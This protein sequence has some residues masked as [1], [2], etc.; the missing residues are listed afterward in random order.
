MKDWKIVKDGIT[1]PELMHKCKPEDN[2]ALGR[3]TTVGP[4]G[5][6]I[7]LD[8]GAHAPEEIGDAALLAKC[9]VVKLDNMVLQE[10]LKQ[11]Q[12]EKT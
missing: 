4:D 10:I 3:I 2:F 12:N 1:P 5:T 6:W 9:R 11:S 8:C 7:C